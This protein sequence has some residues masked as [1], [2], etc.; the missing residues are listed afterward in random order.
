MDPNPNR[1]NDDRRC[2]SSTEH[3]SPKECPFFRFAT[4]LG[5]SDLNVEE[6]HQHAQRKTA[7]IP[8]FPEG[9]KLQCHG[10]DIEETG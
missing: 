6:N 1:E 9:S 5:E 10:Q 2:E 3:H 7:W 4:D 8:G